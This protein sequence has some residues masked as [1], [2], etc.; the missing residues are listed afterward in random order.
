MKAE[1]VATFATQ[2]EPVSKARARF[3]GYG[4][5]VRAYTPEKTL[6]AEAAVA[7]AFRKVG[8]TFEPDKEVTFG[9]DI[10]FHSGTRQRRD[11]DNMIKLILDGLNGVAWVDDTQV[12]DVVA[13][14]RFVD[15]ADARTEVTVYRVGRMSRLTQP[16]VRCGAAFVT[17]RSLRGRQ[18]YCTRDCAYADRVERLSR[19]CKTCGETFQS[20]QNGATTAYCSPACTKARGRTI[21]P[22]KICETPF[23]QYLSWVDAR[24]YCSQDCALVGARLRAKARRSKSFPGTCLICGMGTTRKEYRRCNP[25]KL[26]GKAVPS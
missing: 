12:M 19:T 8:G 21:I 17:Y 26:A 22:C 6:T 11:I 4:S 9:V 10:T 13:R 18:K 20:R 25:C 14:K 15:R 16:C 5:K 24:P 1:I 23:E 2:G 7:A 3:T